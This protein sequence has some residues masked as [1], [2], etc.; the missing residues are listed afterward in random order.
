[1][2]SNVLTF[3]D[4]S[5]REKCRLQLA[6]RCFREDR[7]DFDLKAAE[8]NTGK[9]GRPDGAPA[10]AGGAGGKRVF[11]NNL[12]EDTTWQALKDYFKQAGPVAHADVLTVRARSALVPQWHD[13]A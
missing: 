9:R 13:A 6:R 1:M 10:A 12:A 4:I 8:G 5:L 2:I 3:L 11:V 7:E